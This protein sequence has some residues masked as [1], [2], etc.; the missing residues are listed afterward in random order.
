MVT[1]EL[2]LMMALALIAR[3]LVVPRMMYSK[4][5]GV[6][7]GL[8]CLLFVMYTLVCLAMMRYL[9]C[10][11][12]NGGRGVVIAD[13]TGPEVWNRVVIGFLLTNVSVLFAACIFFFTRDR[14]TMSQKEKMKLK[15]M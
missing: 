6:R 8:G 14:R 2:L 5:A 3:L 9:C 10:Y 15:D 7:F 13:L 11:T 4:S 12:Y 1:I